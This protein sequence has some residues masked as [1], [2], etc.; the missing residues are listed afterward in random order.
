MAERAPRC[1]PWMNKAGNRSFGY[2]EEK[3]WNS[4]MKNFD[5]QEIKGELDLAIEKNPIKPIKEAV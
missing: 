2:K 3:R 4:S 1:E 5:N